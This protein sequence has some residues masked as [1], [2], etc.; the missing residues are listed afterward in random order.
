MDTDTAQW[1]NNLFP[2]ASYTNMD[3]DLRHGKTYTKDAEV[4]PPSPEQVPLNLW[5]SP[6]PESDT[7]SLAQE[8]A[9]QQDLQKM[10]NIIF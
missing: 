6:G 3:K 4:A 9:Y 7:E 10:V 8:K 2:K 1:S 5:D